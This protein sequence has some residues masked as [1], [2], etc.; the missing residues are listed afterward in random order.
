MLIPPTRE[1]IARTI[2]VGNIPDG[3][4]DEGL[5]RLLRAAGS[6]RRWTR[7]TD[8]ND[9]A[10]TFGFAEYDDAQSLETAAEIFKD[11]HVPTKRPNAGEVSMENG[12]EEVE[13]TKLQVMVDDASI[14]Y[15]EEWSKTRKED[16]ETIQFR[17]DSAK[18]TLSQVVASLFNPPNAPQVVQRGD[19]GMQEVQM[20]DSNDVEVAVINLSAAEDEL[21][22]IPAEMR[23]I[24]A[25]EIAAF[26][27]RSTRRDLE[28]LR[29]EEELEAE[30]RRRN[31]MSRASPPPSAPTGP[32][33]AGGANGVPL[34]PK[35]DRGVQGAPSGPK[36]S[37]FPRDYQ[38]G[39]N[40][41]NGGSMNSNGVYIRHDDDDDSAS[42]T[43]IERRH[44]DKVDAE[45]DAEYKKELGRWQK[46]ESRNAASLERT[47]GR[48]K[49]E[50]AE[51]QAARDAQA[52]Q[53][54]NF[55]D[56]AEAASKRHLY[57]R[58][59]GE[60][61]RQR[62]KVREREAKDDA[63]ERS[64][65]QRETAAKQKQTDHARGVADA[66]LDRQAEEMERDSAPREPQHFKMSLGAA[67]KKIEQA[68]AP[69]RTAAD[70]ENLLENDD[71]LDQPGSKKRTLIPINFDAAVRANLTQEEIAD[72]SRQLAKDIPLDKEGLWKWK[73]SWDHLPSKYIENDIKEWA[74]KKILDTLGVT[75]DMLVDAIVG[76]LKARG[77]P[78]ALVEE[79][80][81]VC[82]PVLERVRECKANLWTGSRRRCAAAG[83]E[84]LSYGYLLQ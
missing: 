40:F 79:L 12:D 5:E 10:Q 54:K 41:V 24:V 43:E 47:S 74:E 82:I 16:E 77:S 49:N 21:A 44:K 83:H 63:V 61:M 38:G 20:H 64:Q 69:R 65:E 58:D 27:D 17:Y 13:K 71:A 30:E 45:R 37:Q 42:D 36:G 35:A 22:D 51:L 62:D 14:K 28:R 55:D 57:Y 32:G 18:D 48:Q 78:E 46:H 11:V 56:D 33:G 29:R 60:Y 70:V 4:S 6:L 66:F 7:A 1:E 34:G 2:F 50:E 31:R 15:A 75:E 26:R 72:A 67:A 81:G 8:A 25:A 9:K 80:Q 59:H 76:H 84:A 73:I 68:T 3:V 23:E 52:A 19:M 53:L 39:V